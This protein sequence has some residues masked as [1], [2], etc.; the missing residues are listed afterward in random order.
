MAV[1]NTITNQ[2]LDAHLWSIVELDEDDEVE[3]V[4]LRLAA[5][6]IEPDV[7]D[8]DADVAVAEVKAVVLAASGRLIM[9]LSLTLRSEQL[10]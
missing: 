8:V 10:E 4:V 6:R 5:D 9:S 1:T 7:S 2:A 3:L